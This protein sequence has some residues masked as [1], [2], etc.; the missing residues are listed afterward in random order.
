MPPLEPSK[1][2]WDP[3]GRYPDGS[4]RA[5]DHWSL[6]ISYRQHTLGAYI[7]FARRPV[8]R[9]SELG[10]AEL[11]DLACA[12]GEMERALAAHSGFRP[13]RLNYLQLGNALHHLHFHAVPRY[14]SP[15]SFG[16]REWIDGTFGAP[17]VWS[18]RDEKGSLVSAIRDALAPYLP[19]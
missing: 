19:L 6:E 10:S 18:D 17:P 3:N 4:L 11:A 13:D 1:R 2:I 9:I 5:Y 8:E 16:G 15:R 7:L 14:S 12:M